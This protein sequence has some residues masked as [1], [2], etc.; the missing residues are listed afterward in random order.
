MAPL[1][2][3]DPTG[4]YHVM[5]RGNF[6]QTI[7]PD[8][9]HV[10]RW[11]F[12]AGRV[13][14]RRKWIVIDWCAMPNHFHLLIQLTDDGLSAG[15]RELNGCYS[16]WSNA[17]HELTGTGHLV[18]NRF[19]SRLVETDEYL[20]P[21]LRYI[22]MNPVTATR[23]ETPSEWRWSGYRAIAGLEHPESFHRPEAALR[24]FD[25]SPAKARRLYRDHVSG[26]PV[27]EG[28]D[29]WSDHGVYAA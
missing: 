26:G 16:R 19:R 6:R 12:L 24:Y 22:A 3:V 14:Y 29:L 17:V 8:D 25:S 10:T 5:S 13:A 18:K 20:F 2:I 23:C 7:F 1:R 27:A 15:M 9:D 4:I 11:K 28:L 21:L